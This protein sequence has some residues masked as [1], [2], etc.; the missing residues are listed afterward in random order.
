MIF[1]CHSIFLLA[2][3][4]FNLCRALGEALTK[5]GEENSGP[6]LGLFAPLWQEGEWLSLGAPSDSCT[7]PASPSR[8]EKS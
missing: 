3:A 6:C 7:E 4:E 5:P 8:Y 2:E 1:L